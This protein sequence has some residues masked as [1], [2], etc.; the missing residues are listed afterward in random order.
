M[1]EFPGFSRDKLVQISKSKKTSLANT[2][3]A[4]NTQANLGNKNFK[5]FDESVHNENI[6]ALTSIGQNSVT[7][8]PQYQI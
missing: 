1:K 6:S 8:V 2:Q 7:N 4:Y 3:D 5:D